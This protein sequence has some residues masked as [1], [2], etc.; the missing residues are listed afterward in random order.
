M[1]VNGNDWEIN[2]YYYKGMVI[3]TKKT[4]NITE[5]KDYA[6]EYASTFSKDKNHY[7]QRVAAYIRVSSEE[8]KLHGISLDAQIMKLEEYAA[9]NNLKIVEWYKDEG[10]SGRKLIRKRPELQRML[11]DAQEGKFERILFIKLDRFFRSVAEYHECMKMIDPVLWTA[12]EEKYDLTTANGRAFV[13]MK[14]TIAELEADQTGE[15][16]KIVNDYKVKNGQALTG[17]QSMPFGYKVEPDEHGVKRVVKDKDAEPIVEEMFEHFL[18]HQNKREIVTILNNKYNVPMPYKSFSALLL[19]TMYKGEYRGNKD[20]CPAYLTDDQWDRIQELATRNSRKKQRYTYMFS[21][22]LTCPN[23]GT[24]FGGNQVIQNRV[25]KNGTKARYVYLSYRCQKFRLTKT[26]D[27]HTC[28]YEKRM[29][30]EM[31]DG[32]DR[33]IVDYEQRVSV[34]KEKKLNHNVDVEAVKAELDRLNYAWQKNRISVDDYDRQ[35]DDLMDKLNYA[36]AH[37]E[38]EVDLTNAKKALSGNWREMYAE[39]NQENKKAF[40]RSFVKEIRIK[41]RSISEV[42]FF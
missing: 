37:E 8:Q 20:Y 25:C 3:L 2:L 32:I 18:T 5:M 17:S 40:W 34:T 27:Y 39:L 7:I 10:V 15:R 13:N 24:K 16:I 33:F 28:L 42:D 21:G 35:Y 11:H 31:L 14:L 1:L 12:T 41:D 30:K 23:C 9:K 6:K 29:E 19:N 38:P 26:C 36:T 4:N 22:L